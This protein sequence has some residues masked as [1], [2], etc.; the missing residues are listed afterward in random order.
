MPK[1]IYESLQMDLPALA[2]MLRRKGRGKDT[3]LAHITPKEAELLK[4]RGGR[5]SRNPDTG[6]LEFD[7]ASDIGLSQAQLDAPLP[8]GNEALPEAGLTATPYTEGLATGEIKTPTLGA[9]YNPPQTLDTSTLTPGAQ[10]FQ[11]GETYLGGLPGYA[12]QTPQFQTSV[13]IPTLPSAFDPLYGPTSQ[14]ALQQAEAQGPAPSTTTSEQRLKD[15]QKGGFLDTLTQKLQTPENLLKLGLG[16]GGGV[17]GLTQAARAQN[18]IADVTGQSQA[19]AQ[20]YQQQGQQLMAAAQRGELSPANQQALQAAQAQIQQSIASRGGVGA[21][22]AANQ[23]ANLTNNLLEN[24][25]QYGLNVMQIG[26]NVA[27]GA[28]KDSVSLNMALNQIN[29]QFYT[30]LAQVVG[31]TPFYLGGRSAVTPVTPYG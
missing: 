27:L 28:I 25:Y 10:Q 19:I 20:P 26:D 12:A 31:G 17:L 7:D 16:L 8:R 14:A 1:A 9:N 15:Q 5:G 4:K 13:P 22:Q 11:A 21:Q 6:L 24:Q 3:I 30:S 18:Q 23:I 29:N 2:E